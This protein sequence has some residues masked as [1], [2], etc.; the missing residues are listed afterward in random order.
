[1]PLITRQEKGTKLTIQD[2]DDNLTYLQSNGFVDG[3]YSQTLIGTGAVLQMQPQA[4]L[5]AS[6]GVYENISP[7][8]GSGTGL[9]VDVE[10]ANTGRGNGATYTIVDG[11]SGYKVGDTVFIQN[12]DIGGSPGSIPGLPGSVPINR[13]LLDGD[14]EVTSTST[15]TVTNHDITLDTTTLTVTGSI[16][17]NGGINTTSN[18]QANAGS[19]TNQIGCGQ[20]SVFNGSGDTVVNFTNLPST[21]PV[22]LGQLWNDSGSLKISAGA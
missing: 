2:M 22:K 1:M 5:N 7:T 15:I 14:V 18:I 4:A 11:G 13:L 19:F 16:Y 6:I 8:G 20:L 3:E 17:I 21:D 10:I 9:I 12:T